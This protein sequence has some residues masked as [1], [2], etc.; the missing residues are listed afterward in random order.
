MTG[1]FAKQIVGLVLAARDLDLTWLF[2]ISR[3]ER[4]EDRREPGNAEED[5]TPEQIVANCA[6]W[7]C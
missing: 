1:A 3:T 7:K 5:V 6:R 2:C 4:L